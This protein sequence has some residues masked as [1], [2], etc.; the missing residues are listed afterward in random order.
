MTNPFCFFAS[1]SSSAHLPIPTVWD[2]CWGPSVT[3][4]KLKDHVTDL[5]W[6]CLNALFLQGLFN[7]ET[8]PDELEPARFFW[9]KLPRQGAQCSCPDFKISL[10]IRKDLK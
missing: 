3:I 9:H 7:A 2:T 8:V 5:D 1:F 10:C 6:D 4:L